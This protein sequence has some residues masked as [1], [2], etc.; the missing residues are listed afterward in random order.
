MDINWTKGE[1]FWAVSFPEA[2]VDVFLAPGAWSWVIIAYEPFRYVAEGVGKNEKAA[3]QLIKEQLM[4]ILAR[5]R[6]R[7]GSYPP[8]VPKS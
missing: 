2:R 5:E 4:T 6:I 8:G 7:Q 1:N 3:D